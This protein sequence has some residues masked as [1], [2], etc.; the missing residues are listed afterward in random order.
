M[1]LA[2]FGEAL[3]PAGA[4]G[5]DPRQVGEAVLDRPGGVVTRLARPGPSR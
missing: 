1:H 2:G 3:R 4:A 5:L